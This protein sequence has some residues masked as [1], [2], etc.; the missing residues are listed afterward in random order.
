MI[1][2]HALLFFMLGASAVAI[3][4]SLNSNEALAVGISRRGHR[5]ARH[6]N[7]PRLIGTWSTLDTSRKGYNYLFITKE[8]SMRTITR[9]GKITKETLYTTFGEGKIW[10]RADQTFLDE[11]KEPDHLPGDIQ[12]IKASDTSLAQDTLLF[13][14]REGTPTADIRL[15]THKDG[16]W[17][18]ILTDEV[19]FNLGDKNTI[20]DLVKGAIDKVLS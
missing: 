13:K 2:L 9:Q 14:F 7:N 12:E 4:I 18:E 16:K 1:L 10:F 15:R 17:I 8:G 5:E 6:L 20:T 3:P 19:T 11:R